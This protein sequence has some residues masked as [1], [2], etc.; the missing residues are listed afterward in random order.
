[1]GQLTKYA[2]DTI[3]SSLIYE[4]KSSGLTQADIAERT[5]IAQGVISKYMNGRIPSLANFAIICAA[6]NID[7][8]IISL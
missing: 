5:G 6:L 4:L 1:M 2:K 3:K 7:P 8:R